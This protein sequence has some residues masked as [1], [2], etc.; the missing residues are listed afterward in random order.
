MKA[1]ALSSMVLYPCQGHPCWTCP[2][3]PSANLLRSWLGRG[4]A[5]GPRVAPLPR[6]PGRAGTGAAP[7][8]RAGRGA[9]AARGDGASPAPVPG[10]QPA[11][12]RAL[13]SAAWPQLLAGALQLRFSWSPVRCGAVVKGQPGL[14]TGVP[15]GGTPCSA[16]QGQPSPGTPFSRDSPFQCSQP[17]PCAPSASAAAAR[18]GFG[19]SLLVMGGWKCW[20]LSV[21]PPSFERCAGGTPVLQ[22]L[23]F[24]ECRCSNNQKG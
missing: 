14:G 7:G 20:S 23:C 17:F 15:A 9:G 18:G 3:F 16:G 12:L 5:A 13:R 8:Q 19:R 2:S 21:R 1:D 6:G 24:S 4:A 10:S 22:G 11:P